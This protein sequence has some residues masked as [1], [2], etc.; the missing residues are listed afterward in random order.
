MKY[1]I[2]GWYGTETLGDRAI[3]DGIFLVLEKISINNK[4][5]IG[6]LFPILTERTIAEDESFYNQHTINAEVRC[7]DSKN[8]RYLQKE[9]DSSDIVLMG[10]GPLMDMAELHIIEYAFK[11]AKTKGKVTWLLG[12]GYG[13]LH[14]PEYIL[15]LKNIYKNTDVVI[16]RSEKCRENL[17]NLVG[18]KDNIFASVDPAVFSVTNYRDNHH[19]EQKTG[20]WV[21][22]IRDLDYVYNTHNVYFPILKR[23]VESIANQVENMVLMPMHTFL[24]GGDDRYIESRIAKQINI[25]NVSV[26][27]KPLSLEE[28]YNLFL[29]AQGCIG[30]RYHSIVFQTILNGNNYIVDY[31]DSKDGKIISFLREIDKNDF[32]G[33]RYI[34]IM[35]GNYSEKMFTLTNQ[36]EHFLESES[37]HVEIQNYVKWLKGS[38]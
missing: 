19:N 34:N 31:T 23:I 36:K 1:C 14:K 13:P 8:K 27:Q 12:C 28:C 6:S 32:Y 21:M 11:Y 16:M 9:I 17:I 18:N 35:S 22:N 26:I 2:I 7:F 30:L 4:Y 10:G 15:T 29:T 20:R 33:D 37:V 25:N 3:L 24:I 38:L 5:C